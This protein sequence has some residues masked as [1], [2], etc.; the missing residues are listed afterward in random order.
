LVLQN[1]G[2]CW[3]EL[4]KYVKRRKGNREN[5]PAIKDH[6]GKLITQPIKKANTLNSY[7]ASIFSCERI[8]PQIQSADSDKLFTVSINIIRKRLSAKKSVGPEGIPGQILKLS[9]E[10]MIPYLARLLEVT[11]NNNAIP[12]DRKKL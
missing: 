1:E 5:I 7:Y 11:M 4:Y 12:S 6:N 10:A 8:Y 3:T 2:S 9:G